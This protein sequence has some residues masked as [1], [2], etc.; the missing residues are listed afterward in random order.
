[1]EHIIYL[2]SYLTG[3]VQRLVVRQ[4]GVCSLG[5]VDVAISVAICYGEEALHWGEQA[6]ISTDSD[7]LEARS[8]CG[9]LNGSR[10]V[11]VRI[12]AAARNQIFFFQAGIGL[13]GASMTAAVYIYVLSD[14]M[15]GPEEMEE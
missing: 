4:E 15:Q 1:M 14:H 8:I 9:A 7:V 11:Q 2:L 5:R 6:V 13:N 10:Q 12:R 3:R